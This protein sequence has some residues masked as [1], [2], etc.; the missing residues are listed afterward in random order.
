MPHNTDHCN[1]NH[2]S[3]NLHQY[4]PWKQY[5]L[6]QQ[7]TIYAPYVQI[8]NVP[9]LDKWTSQRCQWETSVQRK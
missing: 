6:K 2:L 4:H 8:E 7:Y 9:K 3:Y 1:P 5:L